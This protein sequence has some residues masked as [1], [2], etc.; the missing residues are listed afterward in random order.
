MNDIAVQWLDAGLDLGPFRLE[1][2]HK[3]IR[4]I[5]FRV[6]PCEKIIRA[7]VPFNLS[8]KEWEQA[9]AAKRQWLLK[10]V[11]APDGQSALFEHNPAGPEQVMFKGNWFPVK[12]GSAEGRSNEVILQTDRID[13]LQ[14]RHCD[15]RQVRAILEKWL[16]E[17]LSGDIHELVIKWE[18]ALSVKVQEYRV[19]KMKTRWGSCNV[20][21][22][23]IWLN[24]ALVHLPVQ[25]LEYVVVHEMVH[26]LEKG[27][28]RRF[29]A[30]M[31]SF[32]PDWRHLN[33]QLHRHSLHNMA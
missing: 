27:H 17:Q 4:H 19:R 14:A 1:I 5:Y 18:S 30:Y 33:D 24:L 25:Y 9:L 16:R 20:R 32:L 10:Q 11:N 15:S 7:S 26:L 2:V 21:A 13:L 29:K 23:R 8:L 28:N 6:I 3:N 12:I 31:D 22:S